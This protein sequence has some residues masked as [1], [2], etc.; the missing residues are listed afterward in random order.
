M[1]SKVLIFGKSHK[2]TE[3]VPLSIDGS[4]IEYV[5]QWKYLGVTLVSGTRLSFSARPDLT[6]F[7]RAAN[8][9]LNVLKEASEDV[10]VKLLQSN[11]L[12]ILTYA[13]EVKEYSASE[14]SDCNVAVNN[15]FRKIFGFRDWRSIRVLR[16]NFNIESIYISFKRAKDK[17]MS[18]TCHHPNPII[19]YLS[20]FTN[21]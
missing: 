18:L 21:S 15:A 4:P 6:S 3:I 9:I 5:S 10:L 2:E 19:K 13:C 17:F 1:K 20:S 7:F 8:A 11:C 14:M 16:D 12:P